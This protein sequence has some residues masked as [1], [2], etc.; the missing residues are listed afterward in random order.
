MVD[1]QYLASIH[2]EID[3]ELDHKQRAELARHLLAD[4]ELRALRDGLRRVCDTLEAMPS[5][6]PPS[7]LRT[8]ILA[9]LPR[10][11]ARVVPFRPAARWSAPA[12][13]LA[14][15]FAGALVTGTVLYQSGV[16]RGPA[17]TDIAGT[18]AGPSERTPGTVDTVR[19]NLGQASGRASLY[20]AGAGF[21]VELELV[22][23]APVDVLVASGGQTK[24]ING[25][26]SP[27]SPGG[28]LTA[29]ELPGVMS[30][31]QRV[32]LTFLV[33]G[34]QIGAATLRI[35]AGR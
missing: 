5:V 29:V 28:P 2:A 4:P 34:H 26:G 21:G 14:A 15:V 27:G 12:W 35:P 3:G 25:L 31:G 16:G 9:A 17:L 10:A 19:L 18:M 32:D 23:S 8:D 11:T 33:A 1:P 22:A 6:D 13:R 20:R 24:R 7:Q 30:P